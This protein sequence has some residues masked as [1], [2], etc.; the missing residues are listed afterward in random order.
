MANIADLQSQDMIQSCLKCVR[1]LSKSENNK[2]LLL[3]IYE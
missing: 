3:I 1:T 2:G